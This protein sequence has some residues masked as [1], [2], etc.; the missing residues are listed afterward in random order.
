MIKSLGGYRA[1]AARLGISATTL[2]SH[3]MA[4]VLPAKFYFAF[5][6]LA[7]ELG[8]EMPKSDLFGFVSLRTVQP[9]KPERDAA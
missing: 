3:M 2:H 8:Q 5:C 1:I 4:N 9:D 7:I 6:E